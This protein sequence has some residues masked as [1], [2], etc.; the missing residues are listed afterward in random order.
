[1][2]EGMA[3]WVVKFLR[4]GYKIKLIVPK[5]QHN[6]TKLLYFGNKLVY[7]HICK[8]EMCQNL[9]FIVHFM[10]PKPCESKKRSNKKDGTLL[11]LL[12]IAP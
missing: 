11:S 5:T 3:I 1:M 10:L 2:T 9:T 8:K 12:K 7:W 4:E 6:P